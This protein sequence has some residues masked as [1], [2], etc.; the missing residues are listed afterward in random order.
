M[1]SKENVIM[2]FD[3][4]KRNK[5]LCGLTLAMR[6]GL[7]CLFL[8]SSLPKIHQPYDFLS[9]V[10]EYELV[11][12]KLGML[13][14]MVVPWLELILGI[15]LIGGIFIGGATMIAIGL[16]AFFTF[17]HASVLYRGLDISCGC[18]STSGSDLI[19][20]GSLLRN[21]FLLIACILAYLG[22]SIRYASNSNY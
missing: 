18:F 2:K 17:A 7:G 3:R 1:I 20:Y 16:M 10:Y 13:S 19:S 11:G 6:L 21:C 14:A 22:L 8:W 15:C 5:L 4:S 12:P 9:N